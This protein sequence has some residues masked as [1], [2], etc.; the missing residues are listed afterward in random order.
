M[1]NN[2]L[3]CGSNNT[4]NFLGTETS[5]AIASYCKDCYIVQV[6]KSAK[7]EKVKDD[8]AELSQK[9]IVENSK[10]VDELVSNLNL[11]EE[12]F[13]L[14]MVTNQSALRQFFKDKNIDCVCAKSNADSKVEPFG[15]E[16][17]WVF[18]GADNPVSKGRQPDL[19]IANNILSHSHDLNEVLEAVM[20]IMKDGGTFIVEDVYISSIFKFHDKA[21]IAFKSDFWFSTH[22]L[23]KA[24]ERHGLKIVDAVFLDQSESDVKKMRWTIQHDH[25][26]SV[27]PNVINIMGNEDQLGYA[28]EEKFLEFSSK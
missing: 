23:G 4:I 18:I 11:N 8:E 22:S 14:E 7:L 19:L 16:Q 2:C 26:F 28:S 1:S 27:S 3:S 13:V 15:I 21:D 17:A 20:L 6:K 5:N 24:C 12:S 10:F 9:Q 25:M